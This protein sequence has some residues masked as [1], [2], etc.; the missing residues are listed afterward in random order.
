[1]TEHPPITGRLDYRARDRMRGHAMQPVGVT[2]QGAAIAA[3][4]SSPGQ[5]CNAT[6]HRNSIPVRPISSWQLIGG[7]AITPSRFFCQCAQV[8]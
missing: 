2:D 4:A 3:K 8:R 1:M 7:P 6:P 5:R